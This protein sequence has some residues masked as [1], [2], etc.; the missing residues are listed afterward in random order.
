[1]KKIVALIGIFAASLLVTTTHRVVS[2]KQ[3]ESNQHK[4]AG[5]I[6]EFVQNQAQT[7]QSR[8]ALDQAHSLLE[9]HMEGASAR[10]NVFLTEGPITY[11]SRAQDSKLGPSTQIPCS[12][13]GL[14]EVR[15]VFEFPQEPFLTKNSVAEFLILC[16]LF[17][18]LKLISSRALTVLTENVTDAVSSEVASALHV[19]GVAPAQKTMLFKILAMGLASKVKAIKPQIDELKH[20]VE[21]A[22]QTAI[23]EAALRAKLETES[24]NAKEFIKSVRLVNHDLQSPISALKV[25]ASLIPE[26]DKVERIDAIVRRIEA[27]A[28]DLLNKEGIITNSEAI[29]MDLLETSVNEVLLEKRRQIRSDVEIKFNY[30][31]QSLTPVQ[32]N[33]PHMKRLIS[34]LVQNAAESMK[35]PGR[36]LINISQLD[37]LARLEVSDTG[38]GIHEEIL[39]HVFKENFTSGKEHGSGLGLTH[40]KACAER[41]GGNIAIS[42]VLG[43][44]TTITVTMPLAETQAHFVGP[45]AIGENKNLVGL[46]DRPNFIQADFEKRLSRK[47]QIFSPKDF[48]SWFTREASPV[49]HFL[50]LD[51]HL[52]E[53]FTGLDVLRQIPQTFERVLTTDDY[54]NSKAVELS[55]ELKFAILPKS[56]LQTLA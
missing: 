33:R 3:L 2:L 51:L 18:V 35:G 8:Q 29:Q 24:N 45:N 5:T 1:M 54:F 38:G 47:V 19:E 49:K 43:R 30:D 4:L 39:P 28:D 37:G 34:N 36:I 53:K 13:T 25:L 12:I 48:L 11:G 31:H 14:G 16:F 17:F 9:S 44:G 41:W 32:V 40:A 46:D 42:S 50:S 27:I 55:Q 26:S 56:L 22:S 52:N 7:G 20:K 10:A 21:I 23:T 15:M 6:C